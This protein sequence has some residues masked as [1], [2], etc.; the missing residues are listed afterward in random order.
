MLQSRRSPC[1]LPGSQ[2]S[3]VAHLNPSSNIFAY[4]AHCQTSPNLS[5]CI[6]TTSRHLIVQSQ[7][8]WEHADFTSGRIISALWSFF[9]YCSDSPLSMV[10]PRARLPIRKQL[11]LSRSMHAWACCISQQALHPSLF[12]QSRLISWMQPQWSIETRRCN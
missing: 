1:C 9:G 2:S 12:P 3:S 10:P 4:S 6:F 7:S 5:C 11:V 8:T